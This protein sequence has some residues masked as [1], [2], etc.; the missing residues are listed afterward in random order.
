MDIRE[1]GTDPWK[2]LEDNDSY[3]AL[4]AADA[5][6]RTGPTSTNV[7]DLRVIIISEGARLAG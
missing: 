6:L 1:S 2:A 3:G 5:L 7:N 4:E